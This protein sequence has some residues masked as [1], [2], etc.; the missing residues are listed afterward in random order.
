MDHNTQLDE[1]TND[2]NATLFTRLWWYVGT[3]GSL[4]F[5]IYLQSIVLLSQF[6]TMIWNHS[7]DKTELL[8]KF[9]IIFLWVLQ[10]VGLLA[11]YLT[12][13]GLWKSAGGN[14]KSRCSSNR[15]GDDDR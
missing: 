14:C 6:I 15:D 1:A 3:S 7:R 5:G 8:T 10:V 2:G 11:F 4:F 9:E 13:L 12:A